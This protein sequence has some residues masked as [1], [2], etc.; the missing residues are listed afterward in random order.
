[1]SNPK[2]NP[3]QSLVP[4]LPGSKDSSSPGLTE[5]LA[6]IVVA[7]VLTFLVNWVLNSLYIQSY[8]YP[9]FLLLGAALFALGKISLT[10]RW[11][12]DYRFTI[13]VLVALFIGGWLITDSAVVNARYGAMLL[14]LT[15]LVDAIYIIVAKY[16]WKLDMHM[17][18]WALNIG[19]DVLA[20]ILFFY[21]LTQTN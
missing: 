12:L 15:F 8:S 5:V 21:S 20:A 16:S 9:V 10:I 2:P 17:L 4:S 13:G 6:G 3:Y 19:G 7:V 14:G 11:Q 18:S 1:M